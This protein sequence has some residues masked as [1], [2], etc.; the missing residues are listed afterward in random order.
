MINEVLSEKVRERTKT[1]EISRNELLT[2]FRERDLLIERT[3]TD[4]KELNAT[5]KGL[6]EIGLKDT[7]IPMPAFTSTN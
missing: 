2:S 7:T 4:L 6:C 3:A 5:I 1:L